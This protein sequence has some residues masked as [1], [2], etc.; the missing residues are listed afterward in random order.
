MR[1]TSVLVL[2]VGLAS[3][4]GAASA[5]QLMVTGVAA[6]DV[7]NI[8]A[9]PSGSAAIVGWIPPNGFGVVATGNERTTGSTRWTEIEHQGNRGWAASRYLAPLDLACGGTEPFWGFT[10]GG[11]GA[12]FSSPE[13]PDLR[14]TIGEWGQAVA[15][16]WPQTVWLS[17]ASAEGVA[18]LS[19]ES[20]SDGMSDSDYAYEMTLIL[21]DGTV[22]SGCCDIGR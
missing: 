4:A 10:M 8:R 17:R 1:M 21:P 14:L 11:S 9:N 13:G 20:C 22:Y 7:L 3:V 15:R 16:P 6:D 2:A 5:Q 18:V 19:E 12:V